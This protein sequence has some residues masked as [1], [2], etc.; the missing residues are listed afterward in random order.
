[1]A[2]Y[3]F[4][5][6]NDID[7]EDPEGQ[8]LDNLA[9]ARQQAVAYARDLAAEAVRQGEVD[10]KHRIVVEDEDRQAL[11]TVS[12]RDAFVIHY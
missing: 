4:R 1:M 2:R 11:L 8:E 7:V 3:F 12:F 5:I 6:M 9:V 10:L